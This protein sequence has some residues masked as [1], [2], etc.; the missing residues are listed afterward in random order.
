M[1]RI[2]MT[3]TGLE[4]DIGIK[5]VNVLHYATVLPSIVPRNTTIHPN[6]PNGAVWVYG[7]GL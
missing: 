7:C 3:L 6:R 4:I 5:F 2:G 1:K